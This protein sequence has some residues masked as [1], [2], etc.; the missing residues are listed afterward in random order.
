MSGSKTNDRLVAAAKKGAKKGRKKPDFVRL[1][2]IALLIVDILIA[3]YPS[4]SQRL[5][6]IAFERSAMTYESDITHLTQEQL[7]ELWDQARLYNTLLAKDKPSWSLPEGHYQ[8]YLETLDPF[9][10]GVMATIEIPSIDVKLP[11]YHE[12]TESVLG[13][14]VGHIPGTSLPIGGDSTHAV[15][16]GHRGLPNA[17]MFT[18]LDD[19]DV[20]D[21]F[22]IHVLDTTLAYEVD[23]IK[24]VL[25]SDVRACRIED[26]KDLVTLVTCTPYAVNTHR[27]LVRG[28]RVEIDQVAATSIDAKIL[29]PGKLALIIDAAVLLS[30]ALAR[31]IVLFVRRRKKKKEEE[32]Q[33]STKRSE[34]HDEAS[35]I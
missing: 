10:N 24:I 11:I 30:L 14:G 23:Q 6:K 5:N 15:L 9:K 16:S 27:L 26:G 17:R 18:D 29:S 13:N 21:I 25:P 4:I 19:I 3:L 31:F 12:V 1:F 20:G 35:D 34:A 32:E 8:Y 22:Y 2:F 7:D 33:Q 28:H